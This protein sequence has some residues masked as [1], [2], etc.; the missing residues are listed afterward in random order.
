MPLLELEF[1]RVL[2]GDDA[3]AVGDQSGE[4][5][6]RVVLQV[7]VA[8]DTMTL[9]RACT[10]PASRYSMFSSSEPKPTSSLSVKE[11]GSGGW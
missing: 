3:V 2:D 7:P 1:G 6:R 9:N 4:G 8:P 5:V 10:R 11:R